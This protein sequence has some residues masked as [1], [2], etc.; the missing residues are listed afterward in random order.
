MS[1]G[2]QQ[3]LAIAR[4]MVNHNRVI[5][6][7]E[8]TKGLAP[9]IIKQLQQIFSSLREEGETILL[10]EQNLEFAQAVGDRFFVLDEG[11]IVYSGEMGELMRDPVVL[12]RYIGV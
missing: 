4:A 11:T 6:I 12:R 3:M 8:P 7:D 9:V 1:G 5:L 2:Q 10:V